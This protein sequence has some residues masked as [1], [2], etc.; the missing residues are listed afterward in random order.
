ML[1]K[2]IETHGK[3]YQRS[4]LMLQS[5]NRRNLPLAALAWL[6]TVAVLAVPTRSDA[7]EVVLN[8]HIND[9]Y[10]FSVVS[11]GSQG[12]GSLIL[13]TRGTDPILIESSTWPPELP[14]LPTTLRY[15]IV[16][17]DNADPGTVSTEAHTE[18]ARE[19]LQECR[20]MVTLATSRPD[21]YSLKFVF[22][23]RSS[24]NAVLDGDTITIYMSEEYFQCRLLRDLDPT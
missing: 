22:R 5:A 19:S 2:P 23:L 4:Q 6:L 9:T 15:L 18:R 24:N 12:Q 14:P 1:R 21:K 3:P 8:L 11:Q 16:V 17:A 13:R 10:N 20:Q 7:N